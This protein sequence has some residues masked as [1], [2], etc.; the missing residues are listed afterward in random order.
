MSHIHELMFDKSIVILSLFTAV[1]LPLPIWEGQGDW[2]PVCHSPLISAQKPKSDSPTGR[3]CFYLK[4]LT[5]KADRQVSPKSE[6]F[7]GFVPRIR[8]EWQMSKYP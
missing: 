3:F 7:G 6:E 2:S 5:E 1:I 4:N 8:A